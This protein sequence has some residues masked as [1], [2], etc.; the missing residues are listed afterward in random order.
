MGYLAKQKAHGFYE[1]LRQFG[2]KD[3]DLAGVVTDMVEEVVQYLIDTNRLE[4]SDAYSPTRER[5]VT[6]TLRRLSS[7]LTHTSIPQMIT[8]DVS[9][10]QHTRP[11]SSG[12]VPRGLPL[13]AASVSS[14][15]PTKATAAQPVSKPIKKKGWGFKNPLSKLKK[16]VTGS[17]QTDEQ[18]DHEN[19]AMRRI[20]PG[21]KG[22]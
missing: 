22:S 13:P 14:F 1:F 9:Q 17:G 21:Q 6:M 4:H 19:E 2:V 16:L 3:K 15:A 11:R 10:S 5:Q 8:V 12:H 18:K 20:V 7:S